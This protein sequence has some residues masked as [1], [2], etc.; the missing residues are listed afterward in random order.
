MRYGRTFT[1]EGAAKFMTDDVNKVAQLTPAEKRVIALVS[2]AKTNKEIAVV[3]GISPATVKRHLENI[4][5]KLQLRNRVE[6]A[7][8][9]LRSIGCPRGADP[10]CPLELCD[11][12]INSTREKWAV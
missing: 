10:G 6:A 11:D 1:D 3:L 8:Y 9:A 5:R 12:E 2:R 7:I 4:L